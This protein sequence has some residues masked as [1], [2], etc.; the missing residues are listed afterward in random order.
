MFNVFFVLFRT[1]GRLSENLYTF[2]AGASDNKARYKCEARNT[3][4]ST[5]LKAEIDL[6][7]LCKFIH[8]HYCLHT[9]YHF[10]HM[11]CIVIN[12]SLI[13]FY[14]VFLVAPEHV[15]I[16]G[17]TEA[18]VGETVPLTCATASS[19]PPAEIKWMVTGKQ[20]KNA[21]TKTVVSPEGIFF[22]Q[23]TGS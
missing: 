19:N 9:P 15:S 11:H 2:T 21:T 10:T 14:F 20:H 1:A 4:I 6:T 3:M 8:V 5:P 18:K 22:F 23:V 13:H 17:A 16:S 7:V 12:F